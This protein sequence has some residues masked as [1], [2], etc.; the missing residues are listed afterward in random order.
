[1]SR[2]ELNTCEPEQNG[3]NA[4]EPAIHPVQGTNRF[5]RP[6]CPGAVA[7]RS[8][9]GKPGLHNIYYAKLTLNLAWLNQVLNLAIGPGAEPGVEPV[10]WTGWLNRMVEPD[11]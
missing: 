9:I 7:L 10:D 6:Y 1:M 2:S 5:N 3:S 8:K 11:G 4:K